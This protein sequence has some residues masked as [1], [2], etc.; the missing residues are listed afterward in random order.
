[1]INSKPGQYTAALD[2][3]I[4]FLESEMELMIAKGRKL[5]SILIMPDY[6]VVKG[7]R[8]VVEFFDDSHTMTK[9]FCGYL[10]KAY[11][12]TKFV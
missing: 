7:M 4:T 8:R 6:Y 9:R 2:D 11:Y 5:Q 1:M 10:K 3:S 12:K